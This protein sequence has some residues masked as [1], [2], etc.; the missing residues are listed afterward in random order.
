MLNENGVTTLTE[1]MLLCE[2]E[3][4]ELVSAMQRAG[5]VLGDRSKIRRADPHSVGEYMKYVQVDGALSDRSSPAA[6]PSRPNRK[7][8]NVSSLG[9]APPP[10][11][12]S[13]PIKGAPAWW[14]DHDTKIIKLAKAAQKNMGGES[15]SYE[16]LEVR[17]HGWEKYQAALW[18]RRK[19]VRFL[20]HTLRHPFPTVPP[21]RPFRGYTLPSS[22]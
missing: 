11:T 9:D 2:P 16:W 7:L 21:P 14:K 3:R 19:E 13:K 15:P 10:R 22:D 4:D 5:V 20:P 1:F 12:T 18:A 6:S 8:S 17:G